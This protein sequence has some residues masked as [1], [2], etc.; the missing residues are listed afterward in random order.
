MIDKKIKNRLINIGIIIGVIILASVILYLQSCSSSDCSKDTA[1]CI[2]NNA[3]LYVQAGCSHC[4]LQEKLFGD[5]LE[6][7]KIV[8]CTKTPE[9][10]VNANI[11]RI[12]CWVVNGTIIEGVYDIGELK[13][14]FGC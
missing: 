14:M 5:K 11:R 12:P 3:V 7:L 6:L 8:D 2:G 9:K 10:C 1:E 13:A 4:S